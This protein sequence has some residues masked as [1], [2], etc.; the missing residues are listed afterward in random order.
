[1]MSLT[2]RARRRRSTRMQM[3]WPSLLVFALLGLL[4]EQLAASMLRWE[5]QKRME[6]EKKERP[7]IDRRCS[8]RNR[9]T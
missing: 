4:I 2:I 1:M 3:C 7:D 6:D 9:A 8:A 5:R